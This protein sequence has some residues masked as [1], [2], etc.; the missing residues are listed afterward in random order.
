MKAK[1]LTLNKETLR[2]LKPA[3]LNG[4]AGGGGWFCVTTHLVEMS[5]QFCDVLWNT[6]DTVYRPVPT[7][8]CSGAIG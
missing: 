5:I 4:V 2:N 7:V 1:K 8:T 6:G 3:E